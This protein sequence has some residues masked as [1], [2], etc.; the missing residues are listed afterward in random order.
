[1]AIYQYSGRNRRGEAVRGSIE[2]ASADA[3]AGQLFNNGITP[4]DINEADVAHDVFAGLKAMRWQL[5]EGKVTLVDQIFFCRQMYTLLKAGVPIM[6]SLRGL[7]DTTQNPALANI[8]ASISEALDAG[9]D[10][11]AATRRHP[12][13]FSPMFVAMVQV[14]ETTGSL[15][16][17]F[18]QLA[19]YLERE[20][21]T[22]ERIKQALRYPIFVLVAIGIAMVI[23][24]LFVIPAFAKIFSSFKAEL[25]WATQ[26]LIATSNFTVNYWYLLL[27]A[28]LLAYVGIRLYV[29]SPDG[30][31]QWDR[32]K[33]G[34]PIVGK[35][36]LRATL[37]RFAR[38]LS[39][40]LRAGVP[41]VQGMGVVGRAVANDYVGERIFQMRDGME[42][43]ET[44]T[45]TATATGLFPPLVVQ[46]ISVGEESGSLVDL[47]SEVA[48][49][50]EREVDYDLKNLGSAIEPVMIVI[51]GAMVLVPALGVFM[52]MWDL[53]SAARGGG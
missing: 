27:F 2:A 39:L 14:G 37:G 3:V 16:E 22:R 23:I 35:T 26:V 8:I 47:L 13:M 52:P 18:L 36:I 43:G 7:R 40:I 25:P 11:T 10:L 24:N 28:A 4:V 45:R 1:V 41:V 17:V 19:Q 6:Q 38:S 53:A 34:L 50:Y 32:L 20:K 30:H 44:V 49:Y 29:N 48:D 51:I 15:P 42:R 21:D 9:M 12:K 33:L 46:M 31:Y 5:G